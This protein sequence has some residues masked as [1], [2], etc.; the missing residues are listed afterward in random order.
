MTEQTNKPTVSNPVEAVVSFR[1]TRF[2]EKGSAIRF[3]Y[4][5]LPYI[6]IRVPRFLARLA[7]NSDLFIDTRLARKTS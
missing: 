2:T 6:W 3:N 7:S 4:M 5:L 1:F